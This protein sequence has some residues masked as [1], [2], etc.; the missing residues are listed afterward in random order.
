VGACIA[1]FLSVLLIATTG[2]LKLLIVANLVVLLAA[3]TRG[4]QLAQQLI[5]LSKTKAS[6]AIYGSLCNLVHMHA[7][8]L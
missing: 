3:A 8:V 6:L 5:A 7:D 2:L 1:V 4:W